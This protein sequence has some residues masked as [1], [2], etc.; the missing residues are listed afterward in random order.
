MTMEIP[1]PG[2]DL[3]NPLASQFG[4]LS[5]QDKAFLDAFSRQEQQ[6][7]H[8]VPRPGPV[9]PN[10]L[11]GQ[12]EQ[13][14]SQITQQQQNKFLHRQSSVQSSSSSSLTNDGSAASGASPGGQGAAGSGSSQQRHHEVVEEIAPEEVSTYPPQN[15]F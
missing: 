6:E 1:I 15:L 2:S 9:D 7:L 11:L 10:T 14:T 5:L 12:L 13:V 8:G 3:V 4:H